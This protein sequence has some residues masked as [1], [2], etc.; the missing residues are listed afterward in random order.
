M[1]SLNSLL[2]DREM[3]LRQQHDRLKLLKQRAAGATTN[4]PVAAAASAAAGVKKT[5]NAGKAPTKAAATVVPIAAA[6]VA[7]PIHP[8]RLAG[9]RQ[10]VF[11]T[12]EASLR[13]QKILIRNQ[14]RA[15]LGAARLAGNA[16]PVE[17]RTAGDAGRFGITPARIRA[18]LEHKPS[19]FAGAE[20]LGMYF[21][22]YVFFFCS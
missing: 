17:H 5:M 11:I 12:N 14:K 10:P 1:P 13:V 15:A 20:N 3:M 21:S 22:F 2:A 18:A 19:R 9:R 16:A 6:V 8:N 7:K 4:K